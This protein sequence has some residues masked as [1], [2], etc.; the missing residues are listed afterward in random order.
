[1]D[2]WNA[3]METISNAEFVILLQTTR[4]LE[5]HAHYLVEHHHAANAWQTAPQFVK[6]VHLDIYLTQSNYFANHVV[7]QAAMFA[8]TSQPTN[9]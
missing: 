9:A 3:K 1:M 5:T 6:S 2:A 8:L 7:L 4:K